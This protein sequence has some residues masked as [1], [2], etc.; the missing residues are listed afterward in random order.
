[1]SVL[2]RIWEDGAYGAVPVADCWWADS[3]PADDLPALEG[4]TTTEVAVIGAGF[5]GLNAALA[6]AEAG[7]GV[8]VLQAEHP[9]WGASGRNGGF[10]CWAAQRP[11][12][13]P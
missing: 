2:K 5:T 11:A 8:T 7:V 12:M 6:L 3:V 9:F 10:C 4:D 13:P 1:M